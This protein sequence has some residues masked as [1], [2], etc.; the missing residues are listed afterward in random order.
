MSTEKKFVASLMRLNPAGSWSAVQKLVLVNLS[1]RKQGAGMQSWLLTLILVVAALGVG[2]AAMAAEMVKDPTTGEMVEAPRY[3]G[4]LTFATGGQLW[5]WD[6]FYGWSDPQL[7]GILEKLAI[8][9]WGVSRDVWD[10][11]SGHPL[12][13]S[14][15]TGRLAESWEMPDDKTL[16]FHI[17]QGVRW[18]NKPP[19]N[20]RL[21]TAQDVEFTFHR[22]LGLG[23]FAEAGPTPFGGA[24]LL[25]GI[26]F[27]S[28]RATD[29]AT[30]VMK[31]KEPY[32][33]AF[34]IIT[35]NYF[36]YI[37]PPEVIQQYGD[38]KD[39][40]NVAGTGP[41][42]LTDVVEGSSETRTRNPDYWGHD[43]KY[44]QNQLPYIDELKYLMIP[45]EATRMSALRSGKIDLRGPSGGPI[46]SIDTV[47][48]LRETH[49]DIVLYK[50]WFRSTNA[51]AA[52]VRKPPFDDLRVRKALQ[53]ALDLET[54]AATYFKGEADPT[55]QGMIGV[56]GYY[57]PFEEWPEAVK[58][59]YRY[60]PEG[61]KQ[62]LAEAGY[63][64]GF[65]SRLRVLGAVGKG[66]YTEIAAAYWAEIGVELE[67]DVFMDW[68]KYHE[69]MFARDYEGIMGS[70]AGTTYDPSM[71]VT[72]YHSGAQWNRP[73]HQ[74]PELD[75]K[76]DAALAATTFEEQQ[77]LVREADMHTIEQHWQ[78]WGPKGPQWWA[79]W[80]WVKG[81]NSE[82]DLGPNEDSLILSRLWIDQDLKKEMGH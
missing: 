82:F 48:S 12:P 15:I 71:T 52:N 41:F 46:H 28:I 42:L 34:H 80:P 6:P 75:A 63:P 23:D 43:E 32:L 26:P 30:V 39:W 57:I 22:M 35:L 61:A 4:T 38:S 69:D 67:I 66:G 74:W 25:Q 1:L 54:V 11:K 81:Y 24:A 13:M 19:M 62:L 29:D 50:Q 68:A 40:K 56:K 59:G 49:P 18:H 78:I 14:A 70:I 55:P 64:N 2:S 9:N 60:D 77:R 5:N 27:E 76:V 72:W 17:R 10:L 45:E 79:L 31:L 33:P 47:D 20:G 16:I 53:M 3:G 7:T 8:G 58:S 44:P 21:L 73:L 65:K 37:V 36:V 51:F